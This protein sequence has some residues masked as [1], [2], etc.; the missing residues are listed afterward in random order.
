MIKEA[1]SHVFIGPLIMLFAAGPG[2][3]SFGSLVDPE[4]L[5]DFFTAWKQLTI[6]LFINE[7]MFYCGHRPVENPNKPP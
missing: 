7:S 1:T 4:D 6:Q 2:L 5:P 3:R